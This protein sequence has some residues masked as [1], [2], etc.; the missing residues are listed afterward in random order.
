MLHWFDDVLSTKNY[1]RLQKLGHLLRV[2][3]TSVTQMHGQIMQLVASAA[4]KVY[5]ATFAVAVDA[6]AT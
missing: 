5:I 4:I 1:Q 3:G 6:A 2:G